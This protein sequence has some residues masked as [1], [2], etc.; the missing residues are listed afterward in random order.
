MSRAKYFQFQS[1]TDHLPQH[2]MPDDA[3]EKFLILLAIRSSDLE[4]GKIMDVA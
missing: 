3:I 1:Y 2:A 4:G